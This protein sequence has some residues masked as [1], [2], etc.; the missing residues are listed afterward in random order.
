MDVKLYEFN[1]AC[2]EINAY[3]LAGCKERKLEAIFEFTSE[4]RTKLVDTFSAL[5]NYKAGFQIDATLLTDVTNLSKLIN[6]PGSI[7]H[8]KDG[9]L[10]NFEKALMNIW[11]AIKD[12]ISYITCTNWR[13]SDARLLSE[14]E[15]YQQSEAYT[16]SEQIIGI[17]RELFSPNTII[18]NLFDEIKDPAAKEAVFTPSQ[19]ILTKAKSDFLNALKA[20]KK[21]TEFTLARDLFTHNYF[22]TTLADHLFGKSPLPR[23]LANAKQLMEGEVDFKKLRIYYYLIYCVKIDSEAKAKKEEKSEQV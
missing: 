18:H 15:Q 12:F 21:D 22:C 16:L 5:K 20:N 3:S 23:T 8:E 11:R 17:E 1:S 6:S 19:D 9:K 4:Q 10:T 7:L 14:I 13:I 2:A